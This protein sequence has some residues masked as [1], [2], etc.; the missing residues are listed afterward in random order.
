MSQLLPCLYAFLACAAFC[1]V[2][3]VKKPLFILLCSTCGAV[4][5]AAFLLVGLLDEG[6]VQYFIATIV[7]SLL[8]EILAR[9]LKAPATIFLI[10]GIIPMVPGGGLYYT[11]DYLINGNLDLF[12][13]KGIQ[14]AAYAG[15]I[16]VGVSMVSSLSR[17]ISWRRTCRRK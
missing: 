11:M 5:W 3:E 1:V 13:Q 2:F 14:T 9:L 16:A 6:V 4:G 15:A 12:V 10:V 17:V 7:V 8:S